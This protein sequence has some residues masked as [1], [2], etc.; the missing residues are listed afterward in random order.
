M[1]YEKVI[2]G[3]KTDA[4]FILYFC[5]YEPYICTYGTT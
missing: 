1:I 4:K 3:I 2:G 5:T